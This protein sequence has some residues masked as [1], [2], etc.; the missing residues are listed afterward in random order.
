MTKWIRTSK[1]STK[2]SLS[3]GGVPVG[4]EC[5]VFIVEFDRVRLPLLPAGETLVNA[6]GD[7]IS[8]N[9]SIEWS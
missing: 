3:L 4:R 1:L 5:E 9:V 2:N 6:C 8:Q 7:F